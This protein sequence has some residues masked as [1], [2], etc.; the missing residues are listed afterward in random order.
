MSRP[1]PTRPERIEYGPAESQHFDIAW[2]SANTRPRGI[3]ILVHGGYWRSALDSSLMAPLILPLT[4]AGW[5]VANVEYRRG[6][7]GPWPAPRLTA[8]LRSGRS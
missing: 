6:A 7:D 4:S 8:T 3:A 5:I 2:P 1:D